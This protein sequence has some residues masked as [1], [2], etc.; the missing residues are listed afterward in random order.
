MMLL[1]RSN[2]ALTFQLNR[3]RTMHCL[4]FPN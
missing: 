1:C 2:A 3:I 4:S